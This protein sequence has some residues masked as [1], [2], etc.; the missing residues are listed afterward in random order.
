MNI[1]I[2]GGTGFIGSALC[3]YLLR[4]RHNIVVKSRQ[5]ESKLGVVDRA[6]DRTID[7]TIGKV[8]L[9]RTLDLLD[10]N[11][12]FD[13]VINLAGEPIANKRWSAKQRQKILNSRVDSTQELVDFIQHSKRKPSLFIS[14]SAIGYYGIET[15]NKVVGE[16]VVGEADVGDD[17]FSSRLC[18]LWEKTALQAEA[19]GVRTCLL[20]TG[21]VLGTNGGVL[22]KMLPPFKFGLGG[23]I[24]TGNQWMP[25]IHLED[26]IAVIAYCIENED[27]RGAINC[28]APNP[29]TNSSFTATLGKTLGRP[30]IFHVPALVIKLLMGDMGK[31]LLLSGK[32]VYP[33]KLVDA[34][35][36]FKFDKIDAALSDVLSS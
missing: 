11:Q 9:I 15:S 36:R 32:R 16:P 30:T 1:L 20:R 29:V 34:G 17:S 26:L 25:W 28:T 22:K 31:E 10:S 12:T 19:L 7:R 4:S 5:P 14:A 3:D 24:G 2:S 18:V 35:F 8:T 21:I 6:I 27:L 23:K 13:I 33:L